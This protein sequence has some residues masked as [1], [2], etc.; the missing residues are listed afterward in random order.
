MF[1]ITRS[2]PSC[3]VRQTVE[4][5]DGR[6]LC[7]N[8]TLRRLPG[9]WSRARGAGASADCPDGAGARGLSRELEPDH[10]GVAAEPLQAGR[11]AR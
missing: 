5:S 1:V 6:P 10:V 11:T 4:M 7:L 2:C 3:G 9:V 8:C